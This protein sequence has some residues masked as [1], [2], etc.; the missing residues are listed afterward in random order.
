MRVAIHWG[1]KELSTEN[2]PLAPLE[3][4][5]ILLRWTLKDIAARRHLLIDKNHLPK[6]VDL[7]LV[8]LRGDVP[9][10]TPAGEKAAWR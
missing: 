4:D 10:L 1:T 8:E 2:D 9:V 7:G 3:S 5:A 6:L